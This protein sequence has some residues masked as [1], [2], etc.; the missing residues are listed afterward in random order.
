MKDFLLFIVFILG[1]TC[2]GAVYD[3]QFPR[4]FAQQFSDIQMGNQMFG[5]LNSL[6]TFLEAGM[7]FIAPKIVNKIGPPVM[8]CYWSVLWWP[9][10]LFSRE[11]LPDQF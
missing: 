2:S 11:S 1:I 4:Y 10:E 9:L 8:R 3:Q 5:Y 6:Q 7:M